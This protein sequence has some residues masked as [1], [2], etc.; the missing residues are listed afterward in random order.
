MQKIIFK[1]VSR[2][3]DT[4]TNVKMQ[5]YRGFGLMF[6]LI[7]T[8]TIKQRLQG[9]QDP[10]QRQHRIQAGKEYYTKSMS[11]VLDLEEVLVHTKLL[12]GPNAKNQGCLFYLNELG[13]PIYVASYDP[14]SLLYASELSILSPGHECLLQHLHLHFDSEAHGR[15]DCVVHRSASKDHSK[16]AVQK[17]QLCRQ[18]RV[19]QFYPAYTSKI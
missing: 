12:K 15:C 11:L 1:N 2:S 4:C 16:D 13:E 18:R 8:F 14:V 5:I 10:R 19:G 7:D 6:D 17:A 9:R 3:S